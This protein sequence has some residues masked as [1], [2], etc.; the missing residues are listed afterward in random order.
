MRDVASEHDVSYNAAYK[1]LKRLEDDGL[2]AHVAF[3]RGG[4]KLYRSADVRAAWQCRPGQGRR[5]DLR[6]GETGANNDG[7][8]R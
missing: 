4:A 6:R 3:G 1:A 5:S 8:P 7:I 2:I